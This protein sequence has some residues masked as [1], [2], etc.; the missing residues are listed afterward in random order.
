MSLVRPTV[1]LTRRREFNFAIRNSRFRNFFRSRRSRPTIF[2]VRPSFENI[3]I[4]RFQGEG[5]NAM[6]FRRGP[7]LAVAWNGWFGTGAA[8]HP[9]SDNDTRTCR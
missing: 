6:P 7:L 3:L 4:H 1:E 2:V 9:P 5:P 8:P